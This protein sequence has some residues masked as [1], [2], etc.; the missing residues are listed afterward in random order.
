LPD[1]RAG[2]GGGEL[3]P[4]QQQ[5]VEPLLLGWQAERAQVIRWF[6]RIYKHFTDFTPLT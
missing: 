6:G 5:F 3:R 4:G 1:E 2:F